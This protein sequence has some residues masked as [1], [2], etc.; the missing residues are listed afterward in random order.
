LPKG[1]REQTE[2]PVAGRDVW[3]TVRVYDHGRL[4]D[5]RTYYSHYSRITGIILVGT[6]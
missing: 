4:I 5:T 6:G 1:V 3:R 2:F